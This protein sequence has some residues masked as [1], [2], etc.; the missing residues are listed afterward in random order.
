M[1]AV[2]VLLVVVMRAVVVSAHQRLKRLSPI[3]EV[4]HSRRRL[5]LLLLLR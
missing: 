4:A 1:L 5:L 2:G 3:G